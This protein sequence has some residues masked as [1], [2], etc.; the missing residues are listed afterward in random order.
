MAKSNFNTDFYVYI[1]CRASDGR[2]FYVGK[3]SGQRA[4]VS[5]GRNRY[6]MNIVKKHGLTVSIIQEGMQEW[7]AHELECELIAL[8][9]RETLCNL[10]DG[11]DGTSGRIVGENEK[12]L[13]RERFIG[14]PGRQWT[15]EQR[16]AQ[17][18]RATGRKHSQ[19]TRNKVSAAKKGKPQPCAKFAMSKPE[20]RAKVS[21]AKKG[22]KRPDITGENNPSHR[23][24]VKAKLSAIFT[25]RPRLDMVGSL[26]QSAKTVLCVETGHVF[27]T[28]KDAVAWLKSIGKSLAVSSNISSACSG[29]LKTAYGFH[30]KYA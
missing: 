22:Q 28:M 17:G 19:E 23:P 11:G 10:T 8:Y 25:G 2:V 4:Y 20:S 12:R 27:E 26:N 30:W 18:K 6:W 21:A 7:W 14:Q 5:Q 16:D 9:G 29:S 1:H 3:G 13:K 24:E 15:Q